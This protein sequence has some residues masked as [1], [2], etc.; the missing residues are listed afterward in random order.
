MRIINEKLDTIHEETTY[1]STHHV[2]IGV[3]SNVLVNLIVDCEDGMPMW[4]KGKTK[5]DQKYYIENREK[6]DKILN[7]YDFDI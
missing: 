3:K 4:T 5:K 7:K 6:I 2:S 1:H